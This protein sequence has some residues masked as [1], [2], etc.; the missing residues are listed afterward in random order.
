MLGLIG[1]ITTLLGII[2]I[3][4][5]SNVVKKES[6]YRVITV[7]GILCFLGGIKV[8]CFWLLKITL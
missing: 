3:W 1:I 8:F 5:V 6:G 7:L 4:P 2:L